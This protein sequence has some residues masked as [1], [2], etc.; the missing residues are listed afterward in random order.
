[1]DTAGLR[2]AVDTVEEEGVKRARE[3]VADS[4][5]VLLV[6]D[7]SQELDEDDQEIF[8]KIE[9]KKKVVVVN[10][11]D[12][13]LK[14]SLEELRSLFPDAPIVHISALKNEGIEDLKVSHL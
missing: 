11:K 9:R 13:P 1:M 4:D 5:L 6:L 2:K 14:I 12:L 8:K 10:K 7:G 3:R